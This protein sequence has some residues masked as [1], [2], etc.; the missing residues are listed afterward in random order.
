MGI[1]DTFVRV[2]C[3]F[4]LNVEPREIPM[5]GPDTSECKRGGGEKDEEGQIRRGRR[6]DSGMLGEKRGEVAEG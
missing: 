2:V 6:G 5:H 1:S 4:M 3:S